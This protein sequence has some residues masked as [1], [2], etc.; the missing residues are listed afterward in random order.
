MT[1]LTPFA[2]DAAST[3]IDKLTIENG[4][5][6]LSLYGSLDITRDRAGLRYALALK[7]LID[8]AVQALTSDPALPQRLP[9]LE[10]PKTVRSPF[11]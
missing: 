8:R 4:R 3:A 7:V 6:R 11:G 2:D 10:K 9:P 1:E 5:D